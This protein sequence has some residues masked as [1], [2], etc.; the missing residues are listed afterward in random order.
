MN[1][2]YD[3]AME[4]YEAMF[5]HSEDVGLEL[6]PALDEA[7]S[8]NLIFNE[9]FYSAI[10]EGD[11]ESAQIWG[12]YALDAAGLEV[13]STSTTADE[14]QNFNPETTDDIYHAADAMEHWEFQGDTQR[15]AQMSQ[16]AV[17]EEFTG[18][19]IN[20]DE[21]CQFAYENGWYEG[22][23]AGTRGEDMNKMLD[24]YGIENEMSNGKSFDDL[25]SC[26][27]NGGRAIVAVDSGEIWNGESYWEDAFN[28][29]C[30]ADHA[31]EVIGFN[32]ETNCVIVNDSGNPNGCGCE[33]PLETF[34]DAWAD[35]DNL[36]I[37]CYNS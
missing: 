3:S 1:D 10:E 17:I 34:V 14:L 26:L 11:Y 15:C 36:M 4:D 16:I 32:P 18:E 12:E 20:P 19:D 25:L 28:P 13:T 37:E 2:L 6:D 33:I 31:I 30:G 35:S 29:E 22:D 7:L 27:E 24:Y 23:D 21:F 9:L 8:E 5:T